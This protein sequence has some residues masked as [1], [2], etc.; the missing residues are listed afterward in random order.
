MKK[1]A[2]KNCKM[3]VEEDV[4]PNCKRNVFST[5]LQGRIFIADP[6]KSDIAKKMGINMKGEFALKVR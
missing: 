6:T 5:S 3:I 1:K 4:C 2:C